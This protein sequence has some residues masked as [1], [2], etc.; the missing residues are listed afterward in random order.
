MEGLFGASIVS[1]TPSPV[2]T[3][4]GY[5]EAKITPE[6]GIRGLRHSMF[7][8][9]QRCID[10]LASWIKGGGPTTARIV[11]VKGIDSKGLRFL[12][13][14]APSALAVFIVLIV[15]AYFMAETFDE[16]KKPK[17]DISAE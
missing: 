11:E 15:Q 4:S 17:T 14:W 10:G 12:R 9:N 8:N 5:I 7:Y 1:I 6:E 13:R 2:P 3:W 16:M